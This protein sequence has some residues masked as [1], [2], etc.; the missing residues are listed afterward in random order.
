MHDHSSGR[1]PVLA[2]FARP[3][4]RSTTFMVVADPHVTNTAEGTW[5]LFHQ[6]EARLRTAL[7]LVGIV[8]VQSLAVRADD[9][10][11]DTIGGSET[12]SR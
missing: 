1:G 6:I 2:R 12:R 10:M 11:A 5:K 4:G 3:T 7:M 9:C 8:I